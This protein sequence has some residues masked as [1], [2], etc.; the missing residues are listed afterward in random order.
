M[1]ILN[2]TSGL[3]SAASA[4]GQVLAVK[5]PPLGGRLACLWRFVPGLLVRCGVPR[6]NG[7]RTIEDYFTDQ[8]ILR[9]LIRIRLKVAKRRHDQHFLHNLNKAH[10]HPDSWR[11]D[12]VAAQVCELLPPRRK[13]LRPSKLARSEASAQRIAVLGI[14]NAVRKADSTQSQ[15][16]WRKKLFFFGDSLKRSLRRLKSFKLSAPHVTFLPKDQQKKT[17]RAIATYDLRDQVAIGITAKLLRDIIDRH[18]TA[19]S[20]AFRATQDGSSKERNDAIADLMSF[21]LRHQ[22][23][24]LYVAEC[25]IQKFFDTVNHSVAKKCLGDLLLKASATRQYFDPRILKIFDAYLASY[26]FPASVEEIAPARLA[27]RGLHDA[28]VPWVRPE[29][30]KYYSKIPLEIGVPQGGALSP[31]IA[32]I[33][34]HSADL[35]VLSSASAIGTAEF[36]YLRYCDDM[37]IISTDKEVTSQLYRAYL[38]ELEQL[39]LP[40]HRPTEVTKFTK[41][42]FSL[43]SRDVYLFGPPRSG[44]VSPWIA[45]LGYHVRY[46]GKLRIRKESVQKEILK[47]LEIYRIVQRSIDRRGTMMHIGRYQALHRARLR[48]IAMSVGRAKVR[49][50]PTS[51]LQEMCW[52]A[53]FSLLKDHPSIKAQLKTLDRA[54][55]RLLARLRSKLALRNIPKTVGKVADHKVLKHYGGPFSYY[56]QFHR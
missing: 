14:E 51:E 30:S 40:F 46:D 55:A 23:K 28:S 1:A 13:W 8:E 2:G 33:V 48:L 35:A 54:R 16:L 12:R 29:L 53:G 31:I 7:V 11:L 42:F 21:I 10:R 39:K 38:R 26:N 22:G 41:D 34:L 18:L 24:K 9:R 5:Y 27:A 20:Y 19:H 37:V 36:C 44:A 3:E 47:Q 43:K 56:K 45:F 25:D 17:Y 49:S 52:S 6:P 4:Q 32:N 15:D 50:T